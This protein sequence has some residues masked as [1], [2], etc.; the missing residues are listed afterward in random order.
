[1]TDHRPL[2]PKNHTGPRSSLGLRLKRRRS[3]KWRCPKLNG[4]ITTCLATHSGKKTGETMSRQ[5]PRT[6]HHVQRWLALLSF[7][8]SFLCLRF[9]P[10]RPNLAPATQSGS[11]RQRCQVPCG[12]RQN[13]FALLPCFEGSR[14]YELRTH[15]HTHTRCTKHTQTHTNRH[16]HSPAKSPPTL[17][18]I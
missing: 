1:M 7:S 3:I 12:D 16:P 11:T 15:T 8:A 4:D 9:P 10:T 14:P 6:G 17:L 5:R 13:A 18:Y 2:R